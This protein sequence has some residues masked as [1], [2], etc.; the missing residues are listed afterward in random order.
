MKAA[1]T[2]RHGL[3]LL[4]AAAL[5]ATKL[6]AGTG[7]ALAAQQPPGAGST[8]ASTRAVTPDLAALLAVQQAGLYASDGAADDSFGWSVALSGDTALVGAR[9]H[10]VGTH[11]SQGVAYVFIRSGAS[12]SQ[13]AKLAA[14]DGAAYD[15]FGWSVAL[16][17]DTALVGAPYQSVHH[18]NQGVAYV[19]ARS[20][21][22]WSQQAELTASDGAAQVEFGTA[23][24]LSGNTALVGSP[25]HAVGS[26]AR[27]GAVYAYTA[28]GSGWSLQA[29]LA[30]SDGAAYDFFGNSV[31]VD[32]DTALIGALYREVGGNSQQGAAYVFV[33]SGSGWS[34]Q[35]DLTAG[36][37]A[38]NDNLGYSVALDDGTAVVGAQCHEV[39]GDALRGAAYVFIR[40]GSSWSEQ[41]ELT[42]S[43]GAATDLFGTSVA[44]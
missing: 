37:G 27:Q 25:Q 42:A 7:I 5:A 11:A 33:R 44:V 10:Q 17:G 22:S 40:S 34:Q 16:S 21:A 8:S 43:D 19:F 26:N 41:A 18:A 38:A 32:D 24:A 15:H 13:Q 14:S 1:T 29:E 28:S 9:S 4:G 20:G 3:V 12:W 39:D 23:V 35:A 30:A 6:L 31:A 2:R 36:D